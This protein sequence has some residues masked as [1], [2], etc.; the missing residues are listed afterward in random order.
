MCLL[1][2]QTKEELALGHPWGRGELT[3]QAQGEGV[4]S[5]LWLAQQW[6]HRQMN[7]LSPPP[8]QMCGVGGF[9]KV[10]CLGSMAHRGSCSRRD[11]AAGRAEEEEPGSWVLP[12]QPLRGQASSWAL[13]RMAAARTHS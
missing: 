5:G 1:G 6:G 11:D 13:I 4:H 8:T 7:G 3:S 12:A 10:Q 2:F 9:G